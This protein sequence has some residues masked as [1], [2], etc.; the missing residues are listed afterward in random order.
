M[1]SADMCISVPG[2][3]TDSER[4]AMLDAC[5]MA[6]INCVKLMNEGTAIA[7]NYGLFR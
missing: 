7:L 1:Y 5:H 3:L 2:Y 6:E 4:K